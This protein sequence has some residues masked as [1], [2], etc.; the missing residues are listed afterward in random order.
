IYGK[1]RLPH[2][3][4]AQDIVFVTCRLAGRPPRPEP[5]SAD[6]QRRAAVPPL[7]S[8]ERIANLFV[9]ALRDGE[10]LRKY[11][12]HA[13]VVMS[14]HVYLVLQPHQALPGVMRWLKSR[15]AVRANRVLGRTGQRFWQRDY[16][17]HRV[18]S[19]EELASIIECVEAHPVTSG[20]VAHPEQWP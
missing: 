10:R 14:N 15:T 7:L 3:V 4:P 19:D 20:L 6:S 2:G 17:D 12:L 9:D 5:R 1:C 8:D 16:F 13:W 18:R 11:D